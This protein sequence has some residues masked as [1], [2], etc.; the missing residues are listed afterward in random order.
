MSERIR[1]GV[2]GA[3]AQ[4]GWAH[5]AHVAA[6]AQ[7]LDYELTAVSARDAALA[8][9]ARAAFGAERAFGDSLAL[10][11]APEIDLVAVTVKVP[12]HRAIVLAALAAGKHVYCEWPLGRDL[13]EAEEMAAAVTAGS[14]VA[15]GLQGLAAPA[16]REAA[17]L[18]REGALGRPLVARVFS[19]TA[20]WG[21][22]APPHYAYLQDRRNG[23]TLET[24]AGGHTLAVIEAIVGAYREVD[25]R[26]STRLKAVRVSDTGETVERTC[27]D[28][29]L[30]LGEHASGCVSTLEVIGGVA[31]RPFSLEVVGEAGWLKIAGH[32][33]GGFQVANLTLETSLPDARPLAPVA[34]ELK[35]PPA[36]VAE[37]YARLAADIA[38][39]QRSVAGFDHAVR[40]TRLLHA[41]DTASSTGRRQRLEAAPA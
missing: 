21:P 3:N 39:E 8:E 33:P 7:L 24:I 2:V 4:R 36:N 13:A 30:V 15:I 34:A 12:E 16:V 37:A 5:D 19:P 6:L 11:R 28:H 1:V 22:A 35:G 25:A 23:A 29:M 27:A 41:I 14:H 38:A 40:L 31:D 20:G 9:A 10:V 26:N 18:V 17:R 32:Q